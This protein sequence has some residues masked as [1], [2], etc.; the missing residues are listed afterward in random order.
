MPALGLV[1]LN[2]AAIVAS[3]NYILKLYSILVHVIQK[4]YNLTNE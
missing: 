4:V 3:Y 1:Y 2:C